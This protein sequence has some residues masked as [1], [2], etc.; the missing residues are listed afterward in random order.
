MAA[1]HGQITPKAKELLDFSV[2][3]SR[4]WTAT[5]DGDKSYMVLVLL[6]VYVNYLLLVFVYV[7][8]F[9]LIVGKAWHE[10]CHC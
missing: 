1:R 5:W 6:Y 3:W 8:V 4:N 9:T 2:K 10:I 7:I